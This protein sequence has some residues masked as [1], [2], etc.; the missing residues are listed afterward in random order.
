MVSGK[1]MAKLEATP[2]TVGLLL[3]LLR[4]VCVHVPT[5]AH[6]AL[7][8]TPSLL[9]RGAISA[10]HRTQNQMPESALV[11]RPPRLKFSPYF[12]SIPLLY[13]A[14]FLAS[15]DRLRGID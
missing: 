13:P 12:R 4:E 7:V 5:T 10:R 15:C 9:S 2:V 14:L 8:R 1:D 3:W 11:H 6:G